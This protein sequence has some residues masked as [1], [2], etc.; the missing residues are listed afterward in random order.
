VTDA[1]SL[2]RWAVRG[3]LGACRLVAELPA[4]GCTP[5][6][7]AQIDHAIELLRDMVQQRRAETPERP[8]P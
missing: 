8:A 7:L 1:Q 5:A 4:A 6:V 2:W 3:L